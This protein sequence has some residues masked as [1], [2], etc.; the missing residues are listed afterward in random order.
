MNP[1]RDR[2]GMSRNRRRAVLAAVLAV[3]LGSAASWVGCGGGGRPGVVFTG[4]VANVTGEQATR[5]GASGRILARVRSAAFPGRAVAQQACNAVSVLACASTL[6]DDEQ[7]VESCSPVDADSCD[8]VS[9]LTIQNG[10]RFRFVDDDGDGDPEEGEA[11]AVLDNDLGDVCNGTTVDLDDVDVNFTS[12]VAHAQ[13]VD[14]DPDT[15]PTATPTATGSATATVTGTPPT[16]TPTLTPSVTVTRTS[17]PPTPG[18]MC[19]NTVPPE[20]ACPPG[21][22]CVGDTDL[23]LNG[24]TCEVPPSPT[25]TATASVTPTATETPTATSTPTATRTPTV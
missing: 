18:Q 11:E 9:G 1:E 15:C 16:A 14:K 8:F 13:G 2:E 5:L 20:M 22:V 24:G 23:E 25:V 3:I 6:D 21:L 17:T 12:G 10:V 4:D 19:G 7:E